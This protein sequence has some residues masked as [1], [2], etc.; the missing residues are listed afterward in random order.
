MSNVW[1]DVAFGQTNMQLSEEEVKG[2]VADAIHLAEIEG[3]EQ[4]APHHL[5]FGEKKRVAIARVL[6]MQTP[7]LLLDEP[8]ANLNP[9]SKRDLIDVLH[10]LRGTLL[11]ATHDLSIAFELTNR[12]LILK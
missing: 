10:S 3:Y 9:Q 8:T 1:D 2:R 4:N 7:I 5:S 6:A 11:I 12:V